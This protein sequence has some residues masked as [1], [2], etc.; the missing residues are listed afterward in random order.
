MIEYFDWGSPLSRTDAER[1]LSPLAQSLLKACENNPYI[2]V[3]ELRAGE[4]LGP[5][6]AIIIDACDGTVPR[7]NPGGI[8]RN[9]RLAI[10]VGHSD[11]LRM[12]VIVRPLRK[13]F[14]ALSHQHP[15][16][17][18]APRALCLYNI[19]WSAVERTWTAERF[20]SRLFWW[21]RE[22]AAL[23]LHREDQPLEQLFYMS[24]YQVLL[25][26]NFSEL[27]GRNGSCVIELVAGDFSGSTTLRVTPT[28]SA[29]IAK[30]ELRGYR[31]LSL[32]V[33][34]VGSSAV[35]E[36]PQTLGQLHERLGAW[37]S[38]LAINLYETLVNGIPTNGLSALS[39]MKHEGL[40]IVVWI[41][42][43]RDGQVERYDAL[44]YLV[45]SSFFELAKACGVISHPDADGRYFHSPLIGLPAGEMPASDW[46]STALIPVEVRIA[47]DAERARKISALDPA[48]ADFKGVLAGAGALGSM[49]ADIWTR[50]A[51]GEWVYVDPDQL[52][53]HNLARHVGFDDQL[54]YSKVDSVQALAR[55]VY[56]N[57]HVPVAI[58]KSI[59]DQ[60]EVVLAAIANASLLVDV[61]TTFSAPRE[62]A[63]RDNV[64]RTASLFL[65]PSGGACVLLLEDADRAIR[66]P[67]LEGQYY[68]AIL[69]EDWGAHHLDNHYGDMWVGGGCRDISVCLP[70]ERVH[71]HA[72]IL[73]R[74]LRQSLLAPCARACV[75][76]IDERSDSVTASEIE[77]QPV[78]VAQ[79]N[80]W[81][82][83]Y[84]DGLIALL[85]KLRERALPC[86]TGG[87]LLG[88][89]DLK[90]KT[91]VLVDAPPAPTDSQ[92][93]PSHFLRGREGQEE[94]LKEAHR[95][96]ANVV[97]YVGEWHS[98]P[99]GCSANASTDDQKLLASLSNLMSG[100][101]LPALMLIM[102]DKE[103]S[104]HLA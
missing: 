34:G 99:Q 89:T 79:V 30:Q 25:P 80:G 27:A 17:P 95:R 19:A 83:I 104:L 62:L 48:T 11:G 4:D 53:P 96:T 61:T 64:P 15:T 56:P 103:V 77:L 51:W 72:G 52:L 42:R 86:E 66:T 68:R 14:P 57:E 5:V 71:L 41:P 28:S 60:D 90:S 44:G 40:L 87:I 36:F 18:D 21:L 78:H 93:S 7:T 69:G 67:A 81:S 85:C 58:S 26:A 101:G 100:E 24:P 47:L 10:T 12:P 32:A 45:M 70:V 49:L 55:S 94:V 74:Q 16:P 6:E 22:S 84:D 1:S 54:G 9:E 59:V 38:N 37:G 75:W 76:S 43:L 92:S 39:E 102:A 29:K 46:L 13:D 23:K 65:T 98:H 91:I 20:L 3:I 33:D 97:D 35:L 63:Q 82:I 31:L 88:V 8:H 73:S 2:E 50:Q